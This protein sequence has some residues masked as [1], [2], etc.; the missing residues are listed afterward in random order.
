[1]CEVPQSLAAAH[2]HAVEHISSPLRLRHVPHVPSMN[3]ISSINTNVTAHR[4]LQLV[5]TCT[6]AR[7]NNHHAQRDNSG[8]DRGKQN[9]ELQLFQD[10]SATFAE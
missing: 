9:P 1:M 3:S 5:L 2:C 7:V 8:I 10:A 6:S 4:T